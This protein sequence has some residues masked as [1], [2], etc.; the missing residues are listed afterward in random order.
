VDLVRG[1][2][3]SESPRH[4]IID[5]EARVTLSVALFVAAGLVAVGDW[6]AVQARR[7]RLEFALKPLTLALLIAATVAAHL[8]TVEPWVVAGLG[9]GLLGDIVLLAADEKETG[10]PFL[11]GLGSFLVGHIC[12]LVA[13]ARAGVRLI[14]VAAGLLIVLGIAA[15]ALPQVLRGAARAAGRE[16]AV[17]VAAYATILAAMAVLAIGTGLVATAIGG[18]TFLI[19]DT[20]LAR[21]RF[22]ARRPHG[23]VLVIATYH[24]AQFLIVLGLVRSF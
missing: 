23:P 13:F 9:F 21:E 3:S 12:Y 17:V 8:G 16:F 5:P 19:S 15:L 7:F 1:P 10:P 22:V 14:D 4:K 18:A 6:G 24:L 2:A 11:I 20:L